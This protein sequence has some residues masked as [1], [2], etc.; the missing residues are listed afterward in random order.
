M[1]NLFL[2]V[3]IF[4]LCE[5]SWYSTH[6]SWLEGYKKCLQ[7]ENPLVA[8]ATDKYFL[9]SCNTSLCYNYSKI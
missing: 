2:D 8:Q 9:T 4:P 3:L 7:V 6:I 5:V 1:I